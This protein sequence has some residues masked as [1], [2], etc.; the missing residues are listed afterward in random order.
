MATT[1]DELRYSQMTRLAGQDEQHAVDVVL[2]ADA[3]RR[4]SV[5]DQP[6]TSGVEAVLTVSTS[7][8]EAKAGGTR[9]SGRRALSFSP[10][11]GNL[12]YGFSASVSPSTGRRVFTNQIV[13]IEIGNCPL[14]IV[15]QGSVSVQV[16]EAK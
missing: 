12:W 9:L 11:N 15:S 14:Y 2:G 10:T 5:D 16:W 1:T 6:L 3:K 7:P 8:V 13:D 4:I